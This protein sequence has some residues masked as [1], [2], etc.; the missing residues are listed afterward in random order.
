[1]LD[2][3][4]EYVRSSIKRRTDSGTGCAQ[5][6]P[7]PNFV[8]LVK[9][10]VADGNEMLAAK[11]FTIKNGDCLVQLAIPHFSAFA[12]FRLKESGT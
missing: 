7:F 5:A 1:M 10:L 6:G 4:R 12:I 8:V 3:V 2:L 11:G 9:P